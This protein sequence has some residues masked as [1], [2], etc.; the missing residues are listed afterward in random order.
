MKNSKTFLIAVISLICGA[1]LVKTYEKAMT[2]RGLKADYKNWGKLNLILNEVSKN[3][4]DTINL[5]DMTDAAIVAALKELDPHSIYMPPVELKE[6]VTQ[7]EGN[8]DGI[9]VQF[10]V[11]NDTAIVLEVIKG[12]P[13]EKAGIMQ[14][15]RLLKVDNKNI[16][17]TKCPQDSM[18]KRMRGKAGT[19][20]KILVKR[21]GIE[22]PFEITRGKIPM[23]SIDAG[24]MV[25]DTTAYIKLSKFTKTTFYEFMQASVNLKNNGMKRLILDLRDNSGGYLDQAYLL[26]N[27]FL[28]KDDLVVY[29]EGLH[30]KREDYKADGTGMFQDLKL[31]VLINENSASSAE[32]LA[33]AIQDNDRGILIGRRSYGKGLVQEP[34]NFTDG[35]GIRLTVARFHT[36]S[37]RCI[38]KPY[39]DD[40]E[41]DIIKRYRDGEMWNRDSMKVDKSEVYKTVKGREVYGG[42]GIIPD[43]FVPIDTTKATRFFILCNKKAT[44]MRFASYMFDRHKRILTSINNFEALDGYLSHLDLKGEFLNFSSS[45][46]GIKALPGEWK[47]SEPYMLPQIK[48]LIGRYS[49]LGEN[50]FYKMY[51][52]IDQVYLKAIENE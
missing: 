23:H 37:G 27:Q 36:P 34:M 40:Y 14:G 9:G 11:P 18:V 8:F 12:G 1:L 50:A 10:N 17:G 13:S 32:I 45:K 15:D 31:S 5:K 3:Y 19:K 2:L 4:V 29:T 49:P 24:F 46:D 21:D 20:V 47:E 38:Q 25:N 41:A 42:G 48:A 30:R 22:I 43:V 52:P 33:G 44:I 39:G 28:K 51:L 16:A 7:L 6:A 35:S 26:S